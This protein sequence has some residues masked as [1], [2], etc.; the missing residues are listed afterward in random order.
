MSRNSAA[1]S[2]LHHQACH[3]QNIKLK[4]S[5]LEVDYTCCLQKLKRHLCRKK[6]KNRLF[7]NLKTEPTISVLFFVFFAEIT[8]AGR[9]LSVVGTRLD[10][11][12]E[13]VGGGNVSEFSAATGPV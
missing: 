13:R 5:N 4:V 10:D 3:L 8:N 12:G 7:E 9:H 2:K 11:G 6:N 1:A